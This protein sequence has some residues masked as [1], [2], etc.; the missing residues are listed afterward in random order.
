MMKWMEEKVREGQ[1]ERDA[2]KAERKGTV[3][4]RERRNCTRGKWERGDGKE[5][6]D[7]RT[8]ECAEMKKKRRSTTDLH[9]GNDQLDTSS[10]QTKLFICLS[11]SSSSLNVDILQLSC[12]GSPALCFLSVFDK[13]DHGG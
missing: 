3:R 13:G 4:G 10:H 9:Q 2:W 1:R 5:R 7:E 12:P 6:K 11:I 8:G